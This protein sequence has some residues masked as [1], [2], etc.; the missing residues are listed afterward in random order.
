MPV[1]KARL[2]KEKGASSVARGMLKEVDVVVKPGAPLG[3]TFEYRNGALIVKSF[4]PQSALPGEGVVVGMALSHVENEAVIGYDQPAILNLLTRN[5]HELKMVKFTGLPKFEPKDDSFERGRMEAKYGL[6]ALAAARADQGMAS[7]A[8]KGNQDADDDWRRA[9]EVKPASKA[10]FST[11]KPAP[12][13]PSPN[14]SSSGLASLVSNQAQKPTTRGKLSIN[15]SSSS[16]DPFSTPARR[17]RIIADV[18]KF[19]LKQYCQ[20]ACKNVALWRK[21]TAASIV[22]QRAWRAKYARLL[23]ARLRHRKWSAAALK[24]Q[25]M[26]RAR[27]ARAELRKRREALWLRRATHLAVLLQNSWKE[28]KMRIQAAKLRA[29]RLARLMRRKAKMATEIQRVF[30]GM[31]GRRTAMALRLKKDKFAQLRHRCAIMI[32]SIVRGRAARKLRASLLR[33]RAR[34][35][36]S[37]IMYRRRLILRR[38]VACRVIQR[39]ARGFLARR[40]A[41]R[42][43]HERELAR[44]RLLAEEERR[45]LEALFQQQVVKARQVEED[46]ATKRA[47]IRVTL[48]M[49]LLQHMAALGPAEVVRWALQNSIIMFDAE[50]GFDLGSVLKQVFASVLAAYPD[51]EA[52]PSSREGPRSREASTKEGVAS[53]EDD[54]EKCVKVRSW[55]VSEAIVPPP[56]ECYPNNW[57]QMA[58]WHGDSA[59]AIGAAVKVER[60]DSA[61]RVVLTKVLQLDRRATVSVDTTSPVTQLNTAEVVFPIK[62]EITIILESDVDDVTELPAI[63]TPAAGIVINPTGFR[64][65]A[66]SSAPELDNDFKFKFKDA[67]VTIEPPQPVSPIKEAHPVELKEGGEEE[68]K[69]EAEVNDSFDDSVDEEVVPTVVKVQFVEPDLNP[70]VGIIQRAYRAHYNKRLTAARRITGWLKTMQVLEAWWDLV[71]EVLELATENALIIQKY[72][73]R[74]L[75]DRM[76]ARRRK[77]AIRRLSA[78]C[79]RNSAFLLDDMG[80][81][82]GFLASEANNWRS[83]GMDPDPSV[84]FISLEA[85]GT[86]REQKKQAQART[87]DTCGVLVSS[88]ARGSGG[89]GGDAGATIARFVCSH[90]ISSDGLMGSVHPMQRLAASAYVPTPEPWDVFDESDLAIGTSKESAN[91]TSGEDDSG[92]APRAV[93]T[94]HTTL[95]GMRIF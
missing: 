5:A 13:L 23:V 94:L 53:E 61:L 75:G 17:R 93:P 37:V 62:T 4:T 67:I 70:Q 14:L 3:A 22:I 81:H 42:L 44:M 29:E 76:V 88:D 89:K 12:V 78:L 24:I 91:G 16:S 1:K 54:G 52:R 72:V 39:V 92:T 74:L 18:S 50:S 48:N 35:G 9:L 80:S 59:E 25:M 84:P 15:S 6:D 49:R 95:A 28:R 73:R 85:T 58:L 77:Q 36:Q 90:L 66:A 86:A 45:R 40:V 64:T 33:S 79:M 83:F 41:R 10:S 71:D 87:I 69:D 21:Q 2:M 43:R 34:I 82:R 55:D 32:Q 31:L 20:K 19:L 65:S 68:N 8:P 27:L 63:I 51:I 30:R 46:T 38:G 7:M 26:V 60:D 11:T 57:G 47:E 56:K